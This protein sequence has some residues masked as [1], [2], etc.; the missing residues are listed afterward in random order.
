MN[1]DFKIIITNDIE[2]M[3]KN[4]RTYK[5]ED[6][7]V[8]AVG[9]DGTIQLVLNELIGGKAKLGIMP[10][11]TGNDFYRSLNEYIE[12]SIDTNIMNVNG[13]YGLN[14]FSLGIDADI[15]VNAEKLKKLPLPRK[16]LYH[17]SVIYTFF[18]YKNQVMGVNGFFEKKTLLAICNGSYYG[19]G[20]LIAPRA[21]ITTTEAF[22]VSAENM[23]KLEMIRFWIEVMR[24]A[25]ED[26][27][28][29][30]LFTSDKEI[31]IETMNTLKGQ[32]DGELIEGNEFKV[33]P[34]AGTI[35]IVNNRKLI[36]EL[37]TKKK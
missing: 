16:Y 8:Y 36:K 29:I 2:T 12:E 21:N 10:F 11:G 15:C 20:H 9:G 5:N 7:I 27:P 30:D 25:H 6:A 1:L 31:F 33:I 14:I 19:G 13:I 3:R 18:K 34:H 23:S 17:I 28:A 26:N 35:N 24:G 32:L 37:T 22:I 4:A